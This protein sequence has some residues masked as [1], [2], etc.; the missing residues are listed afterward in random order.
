MNISLLTAERVSHRDPSDNFIFQR[1][2]LAY[3]E[4]A[5]LVSGTVLEIGTGS[6]Y[7][8]DI[9]SSRTNRFITVDKTCCVADEKL[10]ENTLFIQM[11]VPKLCG[12]PNESVDYIISFQLIEHIEEDHVLVSEINRVLKKGGK[13]ILST[14]NKNMSLTRNPW[15]IREY[16]MDELETLL[17]KK[18]GK[19][20][21][22]GVFGNEKVWSYYENNKRSVESIIRFDFLR[23]QHRLPRFLLQIPYDMLNRWNRNF[24]LRKH[25]EEVT[26]I[27]LEDYF[28]RE[29]DEGC[30]DLFYI[31]EKV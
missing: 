27:Q 15:H 23:L 21:K 17:A 18:F 3:M 19:I 12:F 7:G 1:S 5:E 8:L 14:P 6:G 10:P 4:A 31:A 11:N 9:I 24:L 2:M 29:A 13:L 16:T 22:L 30:F 20:T 25:T 26:N 28:I